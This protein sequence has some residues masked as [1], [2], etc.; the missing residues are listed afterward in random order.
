M[1]PATSTARCPAGRAPLPRPTSS[2]APRPPRLATLPRGHGAPPPG[3][4]AGRHDRA[5]PGRRTAT[6]SR[7]RRGAQPRR[8]TPARWAQVLAAMGETCRILGHLMAPFTPSAAATLHAQ[9]GV[10]AAVR[11]LRRRTQPAWA[12]AVGTDARRL[13]QP[14]RRAA[15]PAGRDAGDEAAEPR[16]RP[17]PHARRPRLPGLVDSH[18]HLQDPAFDA[19]REAVMAASRGGRASSGCWCRATTCPPRG[20][21]VELARA[22]SG[23]HRAAVGMHPHFAAD[24]PADGLD[25]AGQPGRVTRR[26]RRWGRSGST[27]SPQPLA[28]PTCSARPSLAARARGR[29]ARQAGPGPRPRRARR[30]ARRLALLGC[31]RAAACCTASPATPIWRWR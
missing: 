17:E 24:A 13:D 29:A 4:G 1:S 30:R 14:A 22:A 15:L 21:R 27:T 2:S 19:D 7:R 31:G 5:D 9:L 16:F 28:A 20:A 6:P 26:P 25:R 11:R 10:P 3:R 12:A 8:G 23:S 18:C